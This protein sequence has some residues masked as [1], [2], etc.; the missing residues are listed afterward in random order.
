MAAAQEGKHQEEYVEA[1]EAKPFIAISLENLKNKETA[2]N[3]H[4]IYNVCTANEQEIAMLRERLRSAHNYIGSLQPQIEGMRAL[5]Q[6]LSATQDRVTVLSAENVKLKTEN[7]LLVDRNRELSEKL[8]ILRR[9]ERR[10]VNLNAKVQ[11]Q[12]NE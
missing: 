4:A 7:E 2:S 11:R 8:Y 5:A 6:S 12:D 3:I 1:L 9:Q 10:K